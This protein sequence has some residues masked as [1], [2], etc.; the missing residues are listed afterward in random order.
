MKSGCCNTSSDM[1]Y[2]ISGPFQVTLNQHPTKMALALLPRR[3]VRIAQLTPLPP[4]K[5]LMSL[6][7]SGDD[8]L[9]RGPPPFIR[10]TRPVRLARG[11][12]PFIRDT[13]RVGPD[14]TFYHEPHHDGEVNIVY[15]ATPTPTVL[16]RRKGK[17][18]RVSLPP[19]FKTKESFR[20]KDNGEKSSCAR[21]LF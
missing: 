8:R 19:A 12:P 4:N 3:S 2:C 14:N 6:V 7:E 16:Q 9:A 10:D 20:R 13:T 15:L 17:Q 11:P 5:D 1:H 18:L 21:R